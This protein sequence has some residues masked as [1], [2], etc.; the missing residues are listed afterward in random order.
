[1]CQYGIEVEDAGEDVPNS[2]YCI[3][4]SFLIAA[5]DEA[6]IASVVLKGRQGIKG[7][8][9]GGV[10]DKH[11]TV[12]KK[13]SGSS[14]CA[15]DC[16]IWTFTCNRQNLNGSPIQCATSFARQHPLLNSILR[17]TMVKQV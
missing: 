11:C 16:K 5:F 13:A 10:L 12:Q 9:I 14:F 17:R 8:R 6:S 4:A 7:I 1:M 3:Y 15:P 2:L